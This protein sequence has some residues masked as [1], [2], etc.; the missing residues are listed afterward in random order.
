MAE[1]CEW[2][3]TIVHVIFS[4]NLKP[5]YRVGIFHNIVKMLWFVPNAGPTR[6]RWKMSRIEK[7]FGVLVVKIPSLRLLELLDNPL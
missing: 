4:M 6:Q 2:P 5:V 1:L 7:Y 3:T